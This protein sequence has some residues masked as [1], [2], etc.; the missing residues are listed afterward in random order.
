MTIPTR[1]ELYDLQCKFWFEDEIHEDMTLARLLMRIN[2]SLD[3]AL[4]TKIP[5]PTAKIEHIR[6][7]D[8]NG[9]K[10]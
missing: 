8:D 4:L 7:V 9:K 3:W 10:F 2:G 1:F 6:A 5:E